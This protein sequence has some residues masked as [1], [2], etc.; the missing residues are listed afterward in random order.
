LVT[1]VL[2]DNQKK[3]LALTKRQRRQVPNFAG[4]LKV[5]LYSIEKNASEKMRE[6]DGQSRTT[7]FTI[8]GLGNHYGKYLKKLEEAPHEVGQKAIKDFFPKM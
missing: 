1:S 3:M 8:I 4:I 2:T 5:E 6:L 7:T